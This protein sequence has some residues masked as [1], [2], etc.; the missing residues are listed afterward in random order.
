MTKDNLT[1]EYLG[2]FP[3]IT[4]IFEEA[5]PAHQVHTWNALPFFRAFY[6]IQGRLSRVNTPCQ[7]PT[8]SASFGCW[9]SRSRVMPETAVILVVDDSDE[10]RFV[11]RRAFERAHVPNPL[12]AVKS[13][14]E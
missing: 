2:S 11:I 10:D 6:P 7:R 12:Y 14:D 9:D 5:P 1:K 8:K 3:G 4:M 13:G